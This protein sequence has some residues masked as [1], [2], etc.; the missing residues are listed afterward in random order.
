MYTGRIF[1]MTDE[2]RERAVSIALR[3][4]VAIAFIYPPI[5]AFLN[6]DAWLG[7]IPL[8]I[9]D[10]VPNDELFLIAFGLSELILAAWIL[11][12]RRIRIPSIIASVYLLGIVGLNWQYSD[13]LFRDIS[14]LGASIALALRSR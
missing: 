9:R 5:A 10:I 1:A 4:G 8:Y 7:F 6:P 11:F 3:S 14:I 2:T 13:L 12:G